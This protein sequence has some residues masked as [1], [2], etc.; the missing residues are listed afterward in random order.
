M[1]G[2][3]NS[4][5]MGLCGLILLSLFFCQLCAD[6]EGQENKDKRMGTEE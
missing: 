5:G 6:F 1:D 2:G 4:A 3:L